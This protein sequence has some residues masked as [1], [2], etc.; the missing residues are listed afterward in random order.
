MTLTH[1]SALVATGYDEEG[2][3]IYADGRLVAVLVRLSDL[4]EAEAGHWYLEAGF[5]IGLDGPNH[6][7]FDSLDE[8]KGWIADQLSRR[9]RAAPT[10]S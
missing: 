5:G 8:A 1:Q 9:E 7:T 3:L 4:H 10:R 6:E 2:A